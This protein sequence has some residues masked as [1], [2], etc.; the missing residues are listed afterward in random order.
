MDN[1]R[2]L[3]LLAVGSVL[4]LAGYA[5]AAPPATAPTAPP[6][7]SERAAPAGAEWVQGTPLPEQRTEV[8]ATTDGRHI[9]LA[10]GFGPP[11]GDERAT[12]PRTLWRYDPG[13]DTWSPLTEIPEGVHHAP[14]Q[15]HD[16]RLYIL[17]GFRE[18]S[19]EPV[20]NVRVY[21]LAS[22]EWSEGAPMPTPRGASAWAVLDG[23]I[24]VIGG[25]AAGEGAVDDQPEARITED[26]SVNVHEVYD[27]ADD[28]WTRLQPM[29]TPRNHIGAAAVNGRIHVV[30]G[31]ADGDYTLATH[32]IYDP[33][34]DSWSEGPP[35]PTG[36]SGVA[37][38][39]H[40]GLLYAFGGE[41]LDQPNERTF[42]DAE[43]FDPGT[44]TWERLPPMPTA[45]HG[46]GAAAIG[47]AIYV[48][49]GGPGPAFTFGDTNERLELEVP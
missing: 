45:R 25:N 38:L 43:R 18:T 24:H 21:D 31:R 28:R 12:A 47:N 23:R 40:G 10:G 37:V 7:P 4:V 49:S 44:G 26:R 20:A 17:G 13:A 15:H 2:T 35:V 16:G 32:E 36:R 30:L 46:L 3:S 11:E 19:F 22:G 27:P 41:R 29:P 1:R 6:A 39:E 42:D 33:A 48:L 34:T 5:A 14:F 8:S 9:Y